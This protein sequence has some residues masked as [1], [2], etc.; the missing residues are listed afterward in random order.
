MKNQKP[1]QI[2]YFC[3]KAQCQQQQ[4]E[5]LV[6]SDSNKKWQ[7]LRRHHLKIITAKSATNLHMSDFFRKKNIL[8]IDS[9]WV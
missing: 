4:A 7:L 1:I 6:C 9:F 5:V 8:A 3:N 2:N